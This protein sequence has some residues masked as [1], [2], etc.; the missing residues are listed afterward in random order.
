M[1]NVE[2]SQ[3]SLELVV[4]GEQRSLGGLQFLLAQEHK[5]NGGSTYK[6]GTCDVVGRVAL[7]LSGNAFSGE[8]NVSS[9]FLCS[10]EMFPVATSLVCCLFVVEGD[11]ANLGVSA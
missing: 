9:S 6:R 11:V 10:I 5:S 3:V 1:D 2:T 7:L 8:A 4:D